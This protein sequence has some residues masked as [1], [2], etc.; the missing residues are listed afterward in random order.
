M[1]GFILLYK[2]KVIFTV[3]LRI[4]SSTA[5]FFLTRYNVYFIPLITS[6]IR[7]ILKVFVIMFINVKIF[8]ILSQNSSLGTYST[9]FPSYDEVTFM[10]LLY[11][12]LAPPFSLKTDTVCMVDDVESD[13]VLTRFF[14]CRFF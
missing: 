2:N 4:R 1:P 7:F 10:S 9:L 3:E 14:F 11:S 12:D 8:Y 13:T 6:D 5:S